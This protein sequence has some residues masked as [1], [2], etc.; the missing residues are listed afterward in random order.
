VDAAWQ[1]ACAH[2]L[3]MRSGVGVNEPTAAL[4]GSRDAGSLPAYPSPCGG[5]AAADCP[6]ACLHAGI[7]EIPTYLCG[8]VTEGDE[9][10]RHRPLWPMSL[11][12]AEASATCAAFATSSIKLNHMF[13]V[14]SAAGQMR[15]LHIQE[16]ER[17]EVH[18][19]P[20]TLAAS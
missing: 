16:V 4:Y 1:E 14:R 12:A 18:W 3:G 11:T 7:I 10:W 8:V 2:C 19:V 6:G 20:E 15:S 13:V 9:P 5:G 17:C